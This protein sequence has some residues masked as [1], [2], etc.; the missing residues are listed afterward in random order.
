MKLIVTVVEDND[1]PMLMEALVENEV[2]A[3]KLASTGDSCSK[4]TRL[5]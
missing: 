1:V 2:Q 4:A 3:T 5:Y